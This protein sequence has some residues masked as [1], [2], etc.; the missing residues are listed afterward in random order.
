MR[1]SVSRMSIATVTGFTLGVILGYVVGLAIRSDNLP[2]FVTIGA[3]I[4]C[5]VIDLLRR[6]RQPNQVEARP[7]DEGAL[8]RRPSRRE[9]LFLEPRE[10]E[11]VDGTANGLVRR[12]AEHLL[13]R[14]VE[15][16][17]ALIGIHAN[18][19]IHC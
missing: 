5:K 16:D 3:V 10:D 18:D 15:Q 1:I 8:V 17:D 13:G 7:A 12:A 2:F 6:W 4:G 9:T 14:S 19:G 11:A